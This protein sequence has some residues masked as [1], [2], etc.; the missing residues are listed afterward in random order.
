MT[1]QPAVNKDKK[2]RHVHCIW[3][4]HLLDRLQYYRE[5]EHCPWAVLHWLWL[6][7]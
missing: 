4:I 3:F 1:S 7:L 6:L 5:H 2:T